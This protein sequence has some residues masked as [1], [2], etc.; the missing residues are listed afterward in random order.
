MFLAGRRDGRKL[1]KNL[2]IERLRLENRIFYL[3]AAK[4]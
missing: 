3:L 1:S 4:G 2:K